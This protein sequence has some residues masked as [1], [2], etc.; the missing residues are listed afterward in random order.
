WHTKQCM[1]SAKESSPCR[2]R[3]PALPIPAEIPRLLPAHGVARKPLDLIAIG[4]SRLTGYAR[5]WFFSRG[6]H[7]RNH[8]TLYVVAALVMTSAGL[9][10]VSQ[11]NPLLGT[12]MSVAHATQAG[13]ASVNYLTFRADWR[14]EMRVMVGTNDAGTGSGIAV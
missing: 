14:Y 1:L 6:C 13:P 8:F 5:P 11:D 12:W 7:M 10:A 4:A 3:P 9:P 2:L